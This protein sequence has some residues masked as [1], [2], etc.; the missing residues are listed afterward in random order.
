MTLAAGAKPTVFL[1]DYRA[2]AWRIT[3]AEL[4]FDLDAASTFVVAKLHVEQ[5]AAQP[6]A[7]LTLDGEGLELIELRVDG[8]VLD[9]DAFAL[10]A[11]ALTIPGVRGRA[12]DRNAHARSRPIAIP[13]CRGSISAVA[14]MRVSC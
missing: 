5:D 7:P 13:R 2:P 10:D 11:H 1:R 14:A 6:D 12:V 4:E 3:D 9:A 8:R